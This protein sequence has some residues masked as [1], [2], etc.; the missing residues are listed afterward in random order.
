[1]VLRPFQELPS[2]GPVPVEKDPDLA[3]L[4]RAREA[5]R[6]AWVNFEQ[7]TWLRTCAAISRHSTGITASEG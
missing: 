4:H 1:M 3:F 5:Y 6:R 2:P 7:S